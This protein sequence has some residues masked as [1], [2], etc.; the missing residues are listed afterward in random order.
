VPAILE[1]PNRTS[2]WGYA[3]VQITDGESAL[4]RANIRTMRAT[5]CQTFID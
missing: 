5:R 1:N 4:D 3:A 2:I